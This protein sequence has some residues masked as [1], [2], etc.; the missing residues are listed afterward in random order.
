MSKNVKLGQDILTGEK[1][2]EAYYKDSAQFLNAGEKAAYE[3]GE[4]SGAL[5]FLTRGMSNILLMM[6]QFLTPNCPY[7]GIQQLATRSMDDAL[8]SF[9]G[10]LAEKPTNIVALLGK[11]WTYSIDPNLCGRLTYILGP[12]IVR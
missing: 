9:D 6:P 7:S 10:V 1:S 5:A 4:G 8:R 2:K 12:H 11:V 3:G